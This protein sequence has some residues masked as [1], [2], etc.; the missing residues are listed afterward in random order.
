M[1]ATRTKKSLLALAVLAA[2]GTASAQSSLT[3][4]GII[5]AT[6]TWGRGNGA[7][8]ADRFQ[9]TNSGYNSSRLGFRG[10]EDLG[11][12]LAASFWLEAGIN[13]DNGTG[14]ATNIN[15]QP[16]GVAAAPAGTQGLVFARRSTVSLSGNWGELRMG[17][18]YTPQFWSLSIFDPFGCNGVGANVAFTTQITGVTQARAS[19]TIGYLLPASLGGVY[20]QAM[21]YAGENLSNAG[22]AHGDGTGYG[23]RIGYSS[24]PLNLAAASSYTRYATGGAH[25]ANVGLQWDFSVASLLAM[26]ERDGLGAVEARGWLVGALVPVGPGQVRLA[27]SRYDVDPG[28]RYSKWAL[29][30]V[31]NLSKR[32]ALYAT[33]ARLGNGEGGNAALG[34]SITA[35]NT[36]ST[37]LDIGLRHNF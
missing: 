34:A 23:G 22:P 16:S 2:G 32:T 21:Y 8:S 9:L 27:Y 18:D 33:Y 1:N 37:G 36:S 12:G 24:G 28:P 3:L 35:A 6:L 13:T 20:G 5:D 31:Y 10:T 7:G 14:S 30:Y 15:N 11:G 4:F 19:N 26:Y 29:G 25:Q 17:R